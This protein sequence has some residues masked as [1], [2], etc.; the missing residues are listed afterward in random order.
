MSSSVEKAPHAPAAF[1]NSLSETGTREEILGYL[2]EQ[3]NDTCSLSAKLAEMTKERDKYRDLAEDYK[4][5][6]MNAYEA[7]AVATNGVHPLVAQEKT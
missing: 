1:I 4:V 5:K 7:L 3:W 6:L 2:Q